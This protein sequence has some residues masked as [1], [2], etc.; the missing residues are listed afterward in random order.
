[1]S[2][3]VIIAIVTIVPP[4][5]AALLAAY[6]GI[7][8]TMKTEQVK[9]L[10]NGNMTVVKNELASA[11]D[12]IGRLERILMDKEEKEIKRTKRGGGTS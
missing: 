3:A 11:R 1:M 7:R 6:I 4:T 2:D 9:V 5:I 8:N 10:V 12:T